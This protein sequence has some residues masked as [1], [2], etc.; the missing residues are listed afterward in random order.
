MKYI[1]PKKI[2]D[3]VDAS[4]FN[5]ENVP[6]S[7]TTKFMRWGTQVE[8]DE[9]IDRAYIKRHRNL[10]AIVN[11]FPALANYTARFQK[12]IEQLR[13]MEISMMESCG[14]YEDAEQLVLD[15]IGDAQFSRGQQGFYTKELNTQRQRVKD[16]TERQE[17][18]WTGIF[19]N[20]KEKQ[21]VDGEIK[22]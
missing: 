21:A 16:E 22:W 13:R 6:I 4:G 20:K 12:Q 17:N 3:D 8:L 5:P 18:R 11:K 1:P 15:S 14:L 7:E 10:V 19:K 9:I 2:D